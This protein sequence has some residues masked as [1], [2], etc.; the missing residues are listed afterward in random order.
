[1]NT[2]IWIATS[3]GTLSLTYMALYFREVTFA[4]SR[5]P[6]QL[7][8]LNINSTA[9]SIKRSNLFFVYYC[10]RIGLTNI[11]RLLSSANGIL[12]L[13]TIGAAILWI[14][15]IRTIIMAYNL[16]LGSRIIVG[17]GYAFGLPTFIY[18]CFCIIQGEV[19][20]NRRVFKPG[21]VIFTILLIPSVAV[22][23]WAVMHHDILFQ[24]ERVNIATALGV[25]APLLYLSWLRVIQSRNLCRLLVITALL[26][27]ALAPILWAIITR[28]DLK[29]DVKLSLGLGLLLALSISVL[30]IAALRG[31]YSS[32][33]KCW[34]IF[35]R[36]EVSR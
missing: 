10:K 19:N 32:I 2:W 28:T 34:K 4:L 18:L 13:C 24:K 31:L 22:G 3:L 16:P 21:L 36:F 23:I 33:L 29:R 26:Y 9:Q 20:D 17:V 11:A 12:A 27:T 1:M 14:L 30:Q 15:G 8:A 6:E 5:S 35:Q 25:G 7:Q